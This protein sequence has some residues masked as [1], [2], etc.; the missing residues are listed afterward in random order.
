M[1]D[2]LVPAKQVAAYWIEHVLRHKGTKHLQSRAKEMSFYKVY[3]ID[4]ALILFSISFVLLLT[5]YKL[6]LWFAGRIFHKRTQ[7]IKNH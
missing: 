3:M 4:V 6:T 5:V 2:E 7:K 1:R